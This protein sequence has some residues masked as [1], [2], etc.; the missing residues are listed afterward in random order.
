MAKRVV[1]KM[2]LLALTSMKLLMS[3]NLATA[4]CYGARDS[5]PVLFLIVLSS[6]L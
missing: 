3:G 1:Q 5:V 4:R 2:L 6:F